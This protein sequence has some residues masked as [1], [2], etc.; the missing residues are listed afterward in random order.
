VSKLDYKNVLDIQKNIDGTV[1]YALLTSTGEPTKLTEALAGSNWKQAMQEEY[2]ALLANNTWHLVPPSSN[3]NIID[4]K[5]VYRIKKQDAR[6][7]AT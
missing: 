2:D 1:R 4:Y 3:K 5:W 7:V 6:L